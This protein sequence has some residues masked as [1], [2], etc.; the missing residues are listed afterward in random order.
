M[1]EQRDKEVAVYRE[2]P[3]WTRLNERGKNGTM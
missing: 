3:T 2:E 1:S